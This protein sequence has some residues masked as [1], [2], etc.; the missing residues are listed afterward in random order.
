MKKGDL[1]IIL[2]FVLLTIFMT[3]PLIFTLNSA[4]LTGPWSHLD[5]FLNI[6]ILAWDRHILLTEPLNFFNANIFLPAENSLAFSEHL[7]GD[8]ILGMPLWLLSDNPVFIHNFVYLSVLFLSAFGCYLLFLY[9][10]EDK[11]ASIFCGTIFA[12]I[13]VRFRYITLIQIQS[14][15]WVPFIFLYFLRFIKEKKVKDGILFSLFFFFNIMTSIYVTIIITIFFVSFLIVFLLVKG[16]DYFTVELLKRS[17][18]PLLVLTFL[19]F[20]SS[21]FYKPYIKLYSSG[22]YTDYKERT[23]EVLKNSAEVYNY[24]HIQRTDFWSMVYPEMTSDD[25]LFPGFVVL[26]LL[27]AGIVNLIKINS[28]NKKFFISIGIAGIFCFLLS[29]GSR[30]FIYQFLAKIIP[31]LSAIRVPER[32]SIGVVFSLAL[33][34]GI[35]CNLL[36][37]LSLKLIILI[38][39]FIENARIPERATIVPEIINPEP[40]YFWLKNQ[41]CDGVLELP[42]PDETEKMWLEVKYT[43]S[44]VFHWKKIVN[45]YSGYRP[46]VHEIVR[47]AIFKG[48]PRKNTLLFLKN[49]GVKLIIIHTEYFDT[50]IWSEIEKE[51]AR[52]PLIFRERFG[53]D[54]VYEIP[55]DLS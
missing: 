5:A 17:T 27:C 39:F 16:S 47:E 12:F 42:M 31:F 37:R 23:E 7:L 20:I 1:K 4:V 48:F 18:Y 54:I 8:A 51:I 55:D 14:T 32:F 45:G 3:Y 49:I 11:F 43:I 13:S 41:P 34:G 52:S 26:I 6:W 50:G 44:S 9:L 15:H 35:G 22:L 25:G 33:L 36:K 40:V 2:L 19:L 28:W 21:I 29:F 38:L 24:L 53:H 10:T 30:F 46:K